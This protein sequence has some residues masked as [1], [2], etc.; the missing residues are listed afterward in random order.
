MSPE[1]VWCHGDSGQLLSPLDRGHA[2][3]TTFVKPVEH[4]YAM[5]YLSKAGSRP[6]IPDGPVMV[7][8]PSMHVGSAQPAAPR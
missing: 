6:H 2:L 5:G 4:R 8:I 3:R 7:P 1:G